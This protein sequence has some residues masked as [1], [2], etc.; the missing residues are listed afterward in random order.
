MNE[1]P[2]AVHES[3]ERLCNA[4]D[5]LAE[6]EAY[7]DAIASYNEA[8]L[9]MPAPQTEWE[10]STWVLAAIGDACF[11][12]GFFQSGLDALQHAMHCP[13]GVGNPFIHLRLG[14]CALEKG[15][16]AMAAEHLARAYMLEGKEIFAEDDPK[17]FVFLKTKIAPP[18]SGEW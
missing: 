16:D 7:K 14:Q 17:Y 1:L 9:L 8:W 11:L 10:A 2:A 15:L 6:R 5:E 13:S 3:I 18:V 12:G 4:G